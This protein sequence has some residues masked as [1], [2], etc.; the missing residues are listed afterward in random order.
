MNRIRAYAEMIEEIN[1]A[2]R[3]VARQKNATNLALLDSA[4]DSAKAAWLLLPAE[5][6]ASL[7]PPPCRADDR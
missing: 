7:V 6:R 5:W 2:E 1:R 3:R 4:L